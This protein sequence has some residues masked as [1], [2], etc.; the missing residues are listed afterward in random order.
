VASDVGVYRPAMTPGCGLVVQ[1]QDW[2]SALEQFVTDAQ[3]R[4]FCL[5][6]ARE[7]CARQ[8]SLQKVAAGFLAALEITQSHEAV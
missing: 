1:E 5:E 6:Q 8:F 3:L 7:A 2:C 4:R